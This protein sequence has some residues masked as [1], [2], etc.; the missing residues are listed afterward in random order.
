MAIIRT[1]SVGTIGVSFTNVVAQQHVSD[2]ASLEM[3]TGS[4]E[5]ALTRFN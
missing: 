5:L 3:R 4:A 1:K 2:F